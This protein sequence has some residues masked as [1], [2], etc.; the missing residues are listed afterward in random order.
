MAHLT[1]HI[2][3]PNIL[4]H[5]LMLI[6]YPGR[7]RD[8]SSFVKPLKQ[9]F[10]FYFCVAQSHLCLKIFFAISTFSC[11]SSPFWKS[12]LDDENQTR[13]RR[14]EKARKTQMLTVLQLYLKK[15]PLP[16][17]TIIPSRFQTWSLRSASSMS[18]VEER[19][20][21]LNNTFHITTQK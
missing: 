13:E 6:R 19:L 18:Q 3:C 20:S 1:S 11:M 2:L 7:K 21:L 17:G 8:H 12:D 10:S 9:N 5:P 4:E 16:T 15:R 14:K